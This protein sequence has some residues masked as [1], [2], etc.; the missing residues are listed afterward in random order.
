MGRF[1][2][3]WYCYRK[4]GYIAVACAKRRDVATVAEELMKAWPGSNEQREFVELRYPEGNGG[5]IH[6]KG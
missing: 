3:E 1:A 6:I 5:G 2:S 4:I